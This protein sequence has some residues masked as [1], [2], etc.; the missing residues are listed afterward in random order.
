MILV[1][2][3]PVAA[4]DPAPERPSRY[5]RSFGG[6]LGAM[7]VTVVFVAAYVGFRA[8]T[9]EQPDIEPDVD[10][11]SCV[12]LL[13]DADVVVAHPASLPDGWRATAVHYQRSAPTQW[14]LALLTDDD[15]FVGVVQQ[16]EDVD[17]LLHEYV[18][19]H[20]DQ[21]EDA[22]PGN[23]LGATSWQTWSDAGGDHAFSTEPP[24]GPLVG[25]TL[26]VYGS[27]AVADLETV[28][29][30]LTLDPADGASNDCDTDQLS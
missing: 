21:G 9:R 28:V 26:L 12:A 27:A 25:Q 10:Y 11:A 30:L 6:L 5:D 16:E 14:R 7:V 13:Q 17:D 19:E 2:D 29:G 24:S 20:P 15:E 22:A 18:D 4:P 23:S 8:L 3:H 1:T